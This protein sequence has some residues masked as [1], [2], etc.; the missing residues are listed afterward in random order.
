MAVDGYLVEPLVEDKPLCV[1]ISTC[2]LGISVKKE[3]EKGVT[4]ETDLVMNL[5]YSFN[6]DT[7]KSGWVV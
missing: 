1:F 6:S 2:L 5:V 3:R 7:D 4:Y